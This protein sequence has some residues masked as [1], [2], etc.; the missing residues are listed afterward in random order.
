MKI[1]TNKDITWCP[2]CF[3]NQ[4]LQGTEEFLKNKNLKDFAISA[5]IGCHAK[6]FNYLNLPG[7]NTLHGRVIPCCLGMKIANPKLNVLGF[8]GDGDAYNEGIGH[9]IHA[10]R[11]NSNF[12]YVVHD[13]QVFALTVAQPTSTTEKG[14]IDKTNP[15]GVQ[16]HPIN[17]IELM[18]ANGCTFVARVFADAKQIKWVLQ[19]AHKHKGFS[20]IEVLQPCIV[21]HPDIGY[22]ERCYM[23]NKSKHDKS[24]L[25]AALHK[26]KEF[27]YNTKKGKIPL[28]IFYQTKKPVFEELI[29]KR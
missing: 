1:R 25:K 9:L 8:A 24:N 16:T 20:F 14:Y 7:L 4:I 21:F 15:F 27:D 3:N 19:E 29:R 18:L 22:K 13:N 28:G 17:P 12:T 5:G 26:A 11:Y 6:I 23:L 10:C 2:G